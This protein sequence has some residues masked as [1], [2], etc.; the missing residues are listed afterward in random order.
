[1]ASRRYDLFL[2]GAG[3]GL[4]LVGTL[5]S[6]WIHNQSLSPSALARAHTGEPLLWIMD[7][8]PFVLGALGMIISRQNRDIARQ[9]GEIVKLEKAKREAF[10]RTAAELLQAAQGLLGNVSS[11]TATTSETAASVRETTAT[12]N[13]LSQTAT[14]AALTAETVIGLAMESE[15]AAGEG[16]STVAASSNELLKLADEVQGLARRIEALNGQMRDI[17]EIASVVSYVADRAQGVAAQ[18]REQAA[19]NPATLAVA[20]EVERLSAEAH[21]SSTQVKSILSEVHGHML[22]ALTAAEMGSQRAQTGAQ[23][24]HATA[25]T[26]RK[27]SKA[28]ADSARAARDIAQVA[29]QQE[30]GIEHVLRAMN[31]IYV[32]TEDTVSST[33]QVAAEARSLN[34][35]ASN[36]KQAFKT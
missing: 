22:A 36:L 9:A 20:G 30:V 17:F 5:L 32:A 1:M 27:L 25:E 10:A 6:S 28:L 18:A 24:V 4:P 3:V 34:D 15:K 11:F 14:A 23:V 12:M 16:L 35:L 29:Q 19:G 21:K 7:T 31:E 8:A 2:A 13:Q 26:I 33:H